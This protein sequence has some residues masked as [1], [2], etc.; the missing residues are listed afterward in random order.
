[1]INTIKCL[2][3]TIKFSLSFSLFFS[4]YIFV[5]Y[6]VVWRKGFSDVSC[7]IN[8]MYKTL[9]TR[10]AEVGSRRAMFADS[11]GIIGLQLSTIACAGCGSL[12]NVDSRGM[13][14]TCSYDVAARFSALSSPSPFLSLSFSLSLSPSLSRTVLTQQSKDPSNVRLNE[15]H[16]GA[17]NADT[18][19]Y[20]IT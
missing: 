17:P 11:R 10:E 8:D 3:H 19:L 15:S 2:S 6:F 7:G 18:W 5:F 12:L 9:S 13:K 14:P 20:V 1:M 4:H 16:S